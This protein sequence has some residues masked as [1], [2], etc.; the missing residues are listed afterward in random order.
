MWYGIGAALT[1][2]SLNPAGQNL[3][4]FHHALPCS[5]PGSGL[6]TGNVVALSAFV[7]KGPLV[8]HARKKSSL[9]EELKHLAR[10]WPV[11]ISKKAGSSVRAE[12]GWPRELTTP[13]CDSSAC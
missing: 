2:S 11:V 10:T 13:T 1:T 8:A 7:G 9:A 12:G 6:Q 5:P 4:A 3:L